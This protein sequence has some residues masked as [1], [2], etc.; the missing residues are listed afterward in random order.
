MM[1]ANT[2]AEK[3]GK[4]A[5]ERFSMGTGITS[6]GWNDRASPDA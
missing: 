5:M 1:A 6:R 2:M 4:A 3:S